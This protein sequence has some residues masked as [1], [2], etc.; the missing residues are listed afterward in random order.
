MIELGDSTG[1]FESF[2]IAR[3]EDAKDLPLPAYQT[4]GSAGMDLRA[5]IH[6]PITLK[7]MDIVLVPCGIKIALPSGFEAQ[8]RPRSG[9]A[10]NYG[11]SIPNAPGTVDSDYRGE[12]KVPLINLGREDFIINRGERIAQMII[13]K[14][15]RV[16]FVLVDAVPSSER[17]EGG[18]GHTGI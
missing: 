15:E 10:L 18:F 8:V 7:P 1:H 4:P 2:M 16:D 14:F 6:Q 17:N 11:I 5:N 12:I 3:T 13:A 9:L